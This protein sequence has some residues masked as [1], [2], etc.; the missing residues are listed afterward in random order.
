MVVLVLWERILRFGSGNGGCKG[1]AE[2]TVFLGE[3]PLRYPR[4]GSESEHRWA[5]SRYC[6]ER[7]NTLVGD[8]RKCNH[9]KSHRRKIQAL[10]LLL[11]IP[12]GQRVL[13]QRQH[14]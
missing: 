10:L 8:R 11:R 9:T 7:A 3:G 4:S 5:L 13:R 2:K 1:E 12:L 6:P 14:R